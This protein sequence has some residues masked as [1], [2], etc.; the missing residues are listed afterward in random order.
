MNVI[1]LI[2]VAYLVAAVLFI[3]GLKQLTSPATARRGNQLAAVG[4]LIA[5]VATL[6]VR[7]IL[8]P[9]QMLGGLVVGSAIGV[10]LAKRVEMTGM[11]E[12]VAAFN[13][14]G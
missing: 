1:E 5:V 2:D 9:A 14:F 12:L 8:T 7:Q 11:P 6:F 10:F 13:G 4:M 3:S